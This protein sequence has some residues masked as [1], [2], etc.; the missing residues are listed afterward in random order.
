MDEFDLSG[1]VLILV[2]IC[3]FSSAIAA[4]WAWFRTWPLY[5]A[6]TFILATIFMFPGVQMI[7]E[8]E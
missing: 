1:L 8:R 5:T 6:A 3:F 4:N 7:G 2:G